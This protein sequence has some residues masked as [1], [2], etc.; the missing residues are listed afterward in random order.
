VKPNVNG[1]VVHP[2]LS[3]NGLQM[4]GALVAIGSDPVYL[5]SYD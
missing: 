5:M 2:E 1:V 4:D 3:H